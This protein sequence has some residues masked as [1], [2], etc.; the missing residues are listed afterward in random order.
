VCSRSA[1]ACTENSL[2]LGLPA[3]TEL[4]GHLESDSAVVAASKRMPLGENLW[5]AQRARNGEM[6]M[7][8]VSGQAVYAHCSTA[9]VEELDANT[10][11]RYAVLWSLTRGAGVG[12][13]GGWARELEALDLD[14]ILASPTTAAH[15]R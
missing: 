11:S 14:S 8:G 12:D 3:V 10:R 4:P 6:G 9:G 13:A 1:W 7:D 2:H 15:P 5:A